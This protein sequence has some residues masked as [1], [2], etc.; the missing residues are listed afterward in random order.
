MS[1]TRNATGLVRVLKALRDDEDAEKK[2]AGAHK[3]YR[4]V[5]LPKEQWTRCLA[6]GGSG[7]FFEQEDCHRSAGWVPCSCRGGTIKTKTVSEWV[8]PKTPYYG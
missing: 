2:A 1:M 6:C 3:V 7:S 8:W 5:D 4:T